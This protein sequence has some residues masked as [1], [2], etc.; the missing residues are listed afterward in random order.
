MPYTFPV[1]IITLENLDMGTGAV[2]I[3]ILIRRIFN[4]RNLLPA[5]RLGRIEYETFRNRV[6]FRV[7]ASP[8]LHRFPA[9]DYHSAIN[10]FTVLDA[11]DIAYNPCCP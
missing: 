3:Y 1:G 7:Y 5:F 9:S 4:L 11:I 2:F 10:I 6:I 8:G